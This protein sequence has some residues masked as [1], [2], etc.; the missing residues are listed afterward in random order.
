MPDGPQGCQGWRFGVFVVSV[1]VVVCVASVVGWAG[2]SGER[3]IRF[4]LL[5]SYIFLPQDS[6]SYH[7]HSK[8]L[9]TS[10]KN[11]HSLPAHKSGLKSAFPR[12]MTKGSIALHRFPG[13]ARILLITEDRHLATA[14]IETV[15]RVEQVSM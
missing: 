3:S 8:I 15:A 9:Q 10:F 13:R 6:A 12:T 4:V 14:M 7:S 1:G 11:A 2:R 5:I